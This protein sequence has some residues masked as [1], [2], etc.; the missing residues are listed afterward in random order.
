MIRGDEDLTG[1]AEGRTEAQLGTQSAAKGG[2]EPGSV[3]H[4]DQKQHGMSKAGEHSSVVQH[5]SKVHMEGVV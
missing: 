3:C 2:T 4:A 1:T 5:G